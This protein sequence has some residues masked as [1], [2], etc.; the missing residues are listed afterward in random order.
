MLRSIHNRPSAR[1]S[2]PMEFLGRLEATRAPTIGKASNGTKPNMSLTVP[3]VTQL[4]GDCAA[5]ARTYSATRG[6]NMT[7]ER[8]ASNHASQD[9]ARMLIPTAPR[10]C[11]L[12]S[13]AT[14]LLYTTTVSKALRQP[15]QGSALL[16]NFTPTMSSC[17]DLRGSLA[18]APAG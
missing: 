8:P 9:A 6:T 12:A 2:Q 7:T 15:L 4:P 17:S 13:S 16:S 11:S 5:R 10:S 18:T 14:N 3:T 1:Q